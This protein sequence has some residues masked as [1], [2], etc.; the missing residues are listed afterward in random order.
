VAEVQRGRARF[1]GE[2]MSRLDLGKA[3]QPLG[4]AVQGLGRGWGSTGRASHGD[5]ARVVMAGDADLAGVGI[6]TRGVRRCE[7]WTVAHQGH[8]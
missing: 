2:A 6:F 5:R 7:G 1:S 8:L 4:E 3:S